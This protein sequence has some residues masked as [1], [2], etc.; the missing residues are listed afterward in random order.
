MLQVLAVKK[1]SVIKKFKAVDY[2]KFLNVQSLCMTTLATTKPACHCADAL[3]HL[4]SGMTSVQPLC[5][6]AC[7]SG[8]VSVRAA[9]PANAVPPSGNS[10]EPMMKNVI[11]TPSGPYSARI[12][13]GSPIVMQE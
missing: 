4:Y 7:P 13:Q 12:S 10:S 8:L 11:D 6:D 5:P 3:L 9:I 2:Q 1:I